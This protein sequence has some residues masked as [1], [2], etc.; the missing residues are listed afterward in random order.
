MIG[1]AVPAQRLLFR[2]ALDEITAAMTD[3]AAVIIATTIA[4]D[5]RLALHNPEIRK[6]TGRV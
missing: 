5:I 2:C 6:K 4:S 1:A 3:P